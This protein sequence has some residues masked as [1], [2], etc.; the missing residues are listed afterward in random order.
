VIFCNFRAED[1]RVE[2]AS[3]FGVRALQRFLSFA[4]HRATPD[5][6]APET[7]EARPAAS[8]VAAV[9][10]CLEAHGHRV[11]PRVGCAG[12]RVDLGVLDPDEPGRF[13][14][15]IECDAEK[16]HGADVARDRDRLRSQVLESL[17]WRLVRVW[18]TDWY[19][20]RGDAEKRLLDEVDRLLEEDPD[21][22]DEE[23]A[24]P[25]RPETAPDCPAEPA[26][27]SPEAPV[28]FTPSDGFEHV[29][30]PY[31][32]CDSLGMPV[33]GELT[34]ASPE[35]LAR[36]VE[37]VVEVEGPVHVDVV[38][39]RVRTLWGLKRSGSR[40]QEALDGAI[41][42]AVTE[43]RVRREGRFLFP[44]GRLEVPVRRRSGRAQVK[45]DLVSDAEA[46]EAVRTVLRV[47]FATPL[48]GLVTRTS[49]LLG[50][51]VTTP[52]VRKRLELVVE[53]LLARGE[54]QRT[55]TGAVDLVGRE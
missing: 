43:D 22:L 10:A 32:V 33:E 51:Q 6:G 16:Y 48:P 26:S 42:H 34:D 24:A 39:R 38:V 3:P 1:L 47:Q 8:V 21:P 19:R 9:G 4:E 13:R 45:I 54:L 2:A 23:V 36:A 40:V 30:G 55:P 31:E 5:Q 18:S 52:T 12:F 15:G 11:V 35:V 29:V 46:S 28:S 27:A 37:R 14:L 53:R 20:N 44:A 41:E 7:E 50:F 49:R 17:G 25:A